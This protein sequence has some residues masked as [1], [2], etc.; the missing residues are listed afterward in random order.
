MDDKPMTGREMLMMDAETNRIAHRDRAV[1][2][3]VARKVFDEHYKPE[4]IEDM[5]DVQ[6][7]MII[8]LEYAAYEAIQKE[9]ELHTEDMAALRAWADVKWVEEALKPRIIPVQTKQERENR[10]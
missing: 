10:E 8:A 3:S 6:R 9:R 5:R 2:M 1:A 7:M 4:N